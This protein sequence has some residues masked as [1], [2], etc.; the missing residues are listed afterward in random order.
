MLLP[1]EIDIFISMYVRTYVCLFTDR[2][3]SCLYG[4]IAD[5]A[6]EFIYDMILNY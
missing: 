2:D 5:A 3:R 1:S 4:S 6:L